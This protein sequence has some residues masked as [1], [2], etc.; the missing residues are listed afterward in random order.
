MMHSIHQLRNAP[1]FG[2][3]AVEG[4]LVAEEML[5][6]AL[7]FVPFAKEHRKVWSAP[8]ATIILESASQLDSLWCSS[9]TLDG[10]APAGKNFQITDHF[11][12]YGPLVAK[13]GVVFFGGSSPRVIR[14]FSIWEN[15]TFKS[16]SWWNA[17]NKLKHDRFANQELATLRHAVRSVA[18][19]LLAVIYCGKCDTAIVSN[20][21]LDT[22]DYNPRA[23]TTT[24]LI[25]DISFEYWSKIETQLFAHPVG[26]FGA[27]TCNLSGNWRSN[28][29][30]R[31]WTWWALNHGRFVSYKSK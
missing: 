9:S 28:R 16:T 31:F 25:R 8:F 23:C 2:R 30:P 19:L 14:P 29:S 6:D 18:A 24:G 7:R 21:L 27:D 20:S 15:A 11:K 4:L 13:Q 17:Y 3:A 10:I 26:I 12:N 5:S 1:H 22:S